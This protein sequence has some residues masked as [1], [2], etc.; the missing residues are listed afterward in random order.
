MGKDWQIPSVAFWVQLHRVL[1]PG[2]IAC[3]YGGT[4]TD[5][6]LSMGARMGGLSRADAVALL[7]H[8]RT[9]WC[10]GTGMPKHSNLGRLVDTAAGVERAAVGS[11]L[12]QPGVSADGTNR[13]LGFAR[14]MEGRDDMPGATLE[15]TAPASALGAR[16]EGWHGGL[17]PK[18][19]PLLLFQKPFAR[20][21]SDELRTATGWDH[22]HVV[23]RLRKAPQQRAAAARFG[24]ALPVLP[25]EL[26]TFVRKPLHAGAEGWTELRWRN[27]N[28]VKLFVPVDRRRCARCG[29]ERDA[30]PS[31]P[32]RCPGCEGAEALLERRT[33]T[34]VQP[35][36]RGPWHVLAR[37]ARAPYRRWF[38]AGAVPNLLVRGTGAFNIDATRVFT[39]WSERPESW[40]RSGHS[41]VPDADKIAGCPPGEGIVCHPGGR[42]APN[43][44][45]FHTPLCRRVGTRRVQGSLHIGT[46]TAGADKFGGHLYGD[47]MP[48][49]GTNRGY[50]GPDGTEETLAAACLAVCADADCGGHLIARA[51]GA[52]PPCQACG[53]AMRWA[54]AA[55]FF[56]ELSG[57][58]P[59]GAR[60]A[61]LRQGMG[62]GGAE[63]D[64][65]PAIAASDGGASRFFPQVFP[66]DE[67]AFAYAAKASRAERDAGLGGRKNTGLCRK[68][69]RFGRRQIRQIAPLGSVVLI[70][71][72]GTGSE[73]VAALLEGYFVIA[74]EQNPEDAATACEQAEHVLL[75]GEDWV[76]ESEPPED[77]EGGE[78]D[79]EPDA[80][81]STSPA[82]CGMQMS[83]F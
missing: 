3:F 74:I 13:G 38:A 56:D 51:G 22:W 47:S 18:H 17:A 4:Q 62:Y 34:K 23:R 58:R 78:D 20:V 9:A 39:D 79:S 67:P 70:P 46:N 57:A 27:V 40:K 36:V 24:V 21:S 81:E 30:A 48:E 59:S 31:A 66:G 35:L 19:E 14:E 8:D 37:S 71:Y 53:G 61:G 52:P 33:A 50:A 60:K 68:P 28:R 16:W 73:L 1:M 5:D 12:G 11:K 7:G 65:M 69:V 2:A 54:C 83:L 82:A 10:Q 80:Q 63:G 76:D 75:H 29:A 49:A 44:V 43:V 25:G 41:A 42:F 6:L 77:D 72:C 15:I 26:Q 45:L 64:E 55:A 32:L